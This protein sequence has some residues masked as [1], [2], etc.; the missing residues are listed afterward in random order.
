[1][2]NP[3][4]HLEATQ[5]MPSSLLMA[6]FISPNFH[7]LNLAE[8]SALSFQLPPFKRI[9]KALPLILGLGAAGYGAYALLS[10]F[11]SKEPHEVRDEIQKEP[12][13]FLSLDKE[14]SNKKGLILPTSNKAEKQRLKAIQKAQQNELSEKPE[15][16]VLR[17]LKTMTRLGG[18][19]YA[20]LLGAE[21]A[22][23]N[24]YASMQ[25]LTQGKFG[26]ALI[27]LSEAALKGGV[28]VGLGKIGEN[29]GQHVMGGIPLVGKPIG[30]WIGWVV[31]SSIGERVGRNIEKFL[32]QFKA[33]PESINNLKK[34][35]SFFTKIQNFKNEEAPF[36]YLPE[37][38]QP[39]F[40]S[41]SMPVQ[42]YYK[43]G[44]EK[45]R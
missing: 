16:F 39:H 9:S 14:D 15:P 20:G 4:V 18:S 40:S 1:M 27:N 41:S 12:I 5:G 36:L 30:G 17:G 44:E 32:D 37:K 38:S 6:H 10:K 26:D 24:L 23:P 43:E 8:S 25:S 13:H 31:G 29:V 3:Q 34:S 21:I 22:G 7:N 2:N 42:S 45:I 11:R 35:E 19:N 33:P 28:A